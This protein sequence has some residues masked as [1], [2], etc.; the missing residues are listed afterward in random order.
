MAL[1]PISQTDFTELHVFPSFTV[2]NSVDCIRRDRE[3]FSQDR[4]RLFAT[5]DFNN[6]GL[7]E[8][9]IPST[10]STSHFKESS[11]KCVTD[12]VDRGYVLQIIRPV[13]ALNSIA[14]VDFMS[15]WTRTDKNSSNQTGYV[16]SVVF[17]AAPQTY[18]KISSCARLWSDDS[19][20]SPER[21]LT[22]DQSE[23][24]NFV[25]RKVGN[26]SPKC[27]TIEV[28][29]GHLRCDRAR[30]AV[31]VACASAAQ[32]TWYHDNGPFSYKPNRLF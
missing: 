24:G 22:P 3:T 21:S 19:G 2:S 10:F 16:L 9:T 14:V 20:G 8:F 31:S 5:P 17:S 11:S 4:T 26:I 29:H 25:S 30:A 32:L 28:K 18:S 1:Q 27:G 13:M 23:S 6:F 15:F 7:C 12:V